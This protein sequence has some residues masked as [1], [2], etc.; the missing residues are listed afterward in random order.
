M[1]DF[2]KNLRKLSMEST[3]YFRKI[4]GNFPWNQRHIS[5]KS[6]GTFHGINDIFPQNLRHCSMES[7]KLPWNQRQNLRHFINFQKLLLLIYLPS[8]AMET[9]KTPS[10]YSVDFNRGFQRFSMANLEKGRYNL[11]IWILIFYIYILYY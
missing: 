6:T 10:E 5:V 1:E 4:C 7:T 2:Q 8:A 9:L 11:K 3:S